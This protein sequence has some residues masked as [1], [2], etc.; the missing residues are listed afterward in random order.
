MQPSRLLNLEMSEIDKIQFEKGIPSIEQA[1]KDLKT[2]K[3]LSLS[4]FN[5]KA[6]EK[7]IKRYIPVT[8]HYP[9]HLDEGAFI[10]RARLNK[11]NKPYSLVE[12]IDIPDK[13]YVK[14]Y[15]RANLPNS[16]VFYGALDLELALFEVCQE[17]KSSLDPKREAAFITAGQW[18]V[19][20]GEKLY[21]SSIYQSKE[22][23]K[24]RPDLKNSYD[25]N[26]N[27]L[28]NETLN[29]DKAKVL[30]WYIEFMADEFSK[31]NIANTDDYK[32][33]AY[34]AESVKNFNNL[35]NS[36]K[37]DGLCYPSVAMQFK[38]DNVALFKD[39]V[40]NKLELVN[41]YYIACG[42]MNFDDATFVNGVIH[43]AKEIKNGKI[44]W[45]EEL[46][47]P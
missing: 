45:K 13:K 1:Q 14:D 41:T 9:A 26:T 17:Y 21:L 37:F 8:P 34:Y 36:F 20:K 33:S 44:I 24:A 6:L 30:Q 27:F 29:K 28:N 2:L 46:Y 31:R 5:G 16:P 4:D 12:E 32:I 42:N 11:L 35:T 39:A 38:D 40:E 10:F 47:K 3:N 15:G 23:H 7:V 25:T 18:K 43:E 19:K 22:Y